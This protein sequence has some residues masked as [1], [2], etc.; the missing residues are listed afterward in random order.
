MVKQKAEPR[1]GDKIP[2]VDIKKAEKEIKQK[3]RSITFETFR[4]KKNVEIHIHNTNPKIES[5]A[6]D[7]YVKTFNR[8]IQD[9]DIL[10]KDQLEEILIQRGIWGKD[11]EEKVADYYEEIK[12]I[13]LAVADMRKKHKVNK[14][15]LDYYRDKWYE[16]RDKI[17]QMYEEHNQYLNN[18]VEGR[19]NER[20]IKV[21][22]SHCVK[23]ANGDRVWDSIEALDQEEDQDMLYKITQEALLFWAG[24]SQEII[25]VLPAE[26]LFGGEE[27][28]SDTLQEA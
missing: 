10:T 3:Y 1:L 6:T 26:Q 11:K 18:S 8:L 21:R 7:A 2:E 19:A 28:K 4:D 13:E 12:L 24:L 5:E 27:E 20:E 17:A 14:K 15:K 16:Y 25:Q 9:P 22:L 23:F